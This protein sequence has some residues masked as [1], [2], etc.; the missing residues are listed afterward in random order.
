MIID[1]ETPKTTVSYDTIKEDDFPLDLF[2]RECLRKVYQDHQMKDHPK[3]HRMRNHPK[4]P[5]MRNNLYNNPNCNHSHKHNNNCTINSK[6]DVSDLIIDLNTLKVQE[7]TST[8]SKR[9]N[10]IFDIFNLACKIKHSPPNIKKKIVKLI[11]HTPTQNGLLLFGPPGGGK[12]TIA[13]QGALRMDATLFFP[14]PGSIHSEKVGETEKIIEVLFNSALSMSEKLSKPSIIFLDEIDSYFS[15][16]KDSEQNYVRN[17]KNAFIQGMNT[18]KKRNVLV[19]GT[20]NKPGGLDDAFISRFENRVFVDLPSAEECTNMFEIYLTQMSDITYDSVSSSNILQK[21]GLDAKNKNLTGRDIMNIVSKGCKRPLTDLFQEFNK[22]PDSLEEIESNLR[23]VTV[24]DIQE[25]LDM[26]KSSFKDVSHTMNE[27]YKF[28]E[29]C[30]T[31][32]NDEKQKNTLNDV[33]HLM[34]FT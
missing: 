29:S 16:R 25:E 14:S 24:E 23:T 19:I 4:N 31:F 18:I 30:G 33:S 5:Q 15:E 32:S 8:N 6:I 12:T 27:Y 10:E 21:W 26:H 3:N 34:M 9:L 11:K 1:A 2:I 17:M 13:M 28:Q 20:T 22:L 7:I